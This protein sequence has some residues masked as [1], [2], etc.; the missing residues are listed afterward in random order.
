MTISMM[1]LYQTSS[2]DKTLFLI[3]PPTMLCGSSALAWRMFGPNTVAK[4]W[5][6]IL[7]PLEKLWTSL[8]NLHTHTHTHSHVG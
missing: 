7:L 5:Q 8:R 1:Y 6:F 2:E 3:I 4:F